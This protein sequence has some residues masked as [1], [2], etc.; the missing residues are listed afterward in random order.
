MTSRRSRVRC[1]LAASLVLGM[2][3]GK[4]ASEPSGPPPELTG[5]AAVPVTAEVV[6]G[7]DIAK[8]ID[9]PVIDRAF[10]QL[11]QNPTLAQ[12]WQHL[13]DDCKIDIAKQIKKV[14]L[15][16]GPH[17]G[18]EPG[19]GPVLMVIVGAIPEAELKE[20]VS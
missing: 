11:L 2:G 8:L 5:L 16:I 19:T 12:R 6:I 14:M 10:D 20:C 3:C 18:A 9:A 1:V 7:A 4:K 15:A 17:A 13:H